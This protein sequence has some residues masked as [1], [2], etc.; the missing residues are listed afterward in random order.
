MAHVLCGLL[1]GIG[2]LLFTLFA[3]PEIPETVTAM[4]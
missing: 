3:R 4:K 1:A 2:G